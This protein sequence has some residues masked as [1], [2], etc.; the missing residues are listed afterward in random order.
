MGE[1]FL[2]TFI[3]LIEARHSKEQVDNGNFVKVVRARALD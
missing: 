1:A 3:A 2:S